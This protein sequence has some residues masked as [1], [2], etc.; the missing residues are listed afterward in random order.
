MNELKDFFL[1]LGGQGTKRIQK[2][3]FH[4]G[5]CPEGIME[6]IAVLTVLPDQIVYGHM[7]KF[8]Q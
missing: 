1:A 4:F 5:Q 6:R 8:C 2:G 3:F 7:I